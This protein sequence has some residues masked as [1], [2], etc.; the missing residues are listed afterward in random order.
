MGGLGNPHKIKG[1]VLIPGLPIVGNTFQLINNPAK[2]CIEWSKKYEASIFQIRLG[3]KRIVVV[4]S[5]EDVQNIWLK[6]SRATNSRPVLYTFHHIVSST[7]GFTIG[8]T[9]EGPSFQRKKKAISM[10]LNYRS[11]MDLSDVIDNETRYTIRKLITKNSELSGPPSCNMFRYVRTELADINLM[12]YGQLFALRSSIFITYGFYLDCYNK[13]AKLA[14]EIINVENKIIRFRSPISNLRDF[15]PFLRYIPGMESKADLFGKKRNEYMNHL[16]RI[17]KKKLALGESLAMNSLVGQLLASEKNKLTTSEIQSV[18]LTMVSAGLDN[19]PLNFNHVMGHLSQPY[20]ESIQEKVFAEILSKSNNDICI[21]WDNLAH[22]MDCEYLKAVIKE[23]LR[24]F[25]VLPLSLP[26]TTTKDISYKGAKIPKNTTL[27]MNAYAANHDSKVFPYPDVFI[28]DRWIDPI[29]KTVISKGEL[30]HF[31]FG[32]GSRMCSGNH[33][34]F[35]ELYTLTGRMILFFKIKPPVGDTK[36]LLDPFEN[37][38]H[39]RATSFEPK[40]FK[41][42]LE[43]RFHDGSND[44][45]NKILKT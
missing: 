13:D 23:T 35:K 16:F 43:P 19:T 39:P 24:Y 20:G 37:N 18:C 12:P 4:N 26:R 6:N 30:F 31:S 33:L 5:F 42:R 27:F 7:Q 38:E 34:A 10:L 1:M 17:L 11:V 9:P 29:S 45:Y 8:S 32:A 14:Q 3:I 25:T 40:L 21:A 44:L 15:L 2:K 28:P 36:M 22:S 41:V